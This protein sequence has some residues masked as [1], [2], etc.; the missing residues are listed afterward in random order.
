MDL[1]D[2]FSIY[3]DKFSD[4]D[5]VITK[6]LIE[7]KRVLK[8]LT[9]KD[10]VDYTGISK[11]SILKF[12]QKIGFSN[13]NELKYFF[14]LEERNFDDIKSKIDNLY[15]IY[16]KVSNLNMSLLFSNLKNH[17]KINIIANQLKHRFLANYLSTEFFKLRIQINVLDFESE[18][19]N[20]LRKSDDK[21]MIIL[22]SKPNKLTF[23][24]YLE[25]RNK[26]NR[27][28]ISINSSNP[29]NKFISSLDIINDDMTLYEMIFSTDILIERFK[30]EF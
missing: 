13:F 3:Y 25:N 23:S 27:N 12:C 4:T 10:L 8:S 21:A 30:N 20:Y 19:N 1:I 18:I 28:L 29:I 5:F 15:T 24:K 2:Y 7:N 22:L 16:Y 14:H 17:Q 9:T 6:F 26:L 11:P